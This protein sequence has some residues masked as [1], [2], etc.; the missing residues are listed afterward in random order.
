MCVR[1]LAARMVENKQGKGSTN[2][3]NLVQASGDG[4]HQNERNNVAHHK[5]AGGEFQE[6]SERYG[7][8]GTVNVR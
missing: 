1:V 5:P 7:S 2:A 8:A 3:T 6:E 4:K